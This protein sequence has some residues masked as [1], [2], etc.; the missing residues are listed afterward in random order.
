MFTFGLTPPAVFGAA[1]PKG[2]YA[3]LTTRGWEAS[4]TWNDKVGNGK[5]PFRYNVRLTLSD[6]K[7][8]IDRYNNP[9]KLISDFYEGQTLGE[10]WG[11]ETEGFF[12]DAADIASHAKQNPQMRAS[13]S[14]IWYPGDIKLRDLNKDNLINVGENKVGNSGDRRIIGN[15][16]PRYNFG[17]NLGADYNNFSFSTFFQG[18]GK[19]QWYPSTEA[20]MFWGQY[21]RPYNNIPIFH[22]G[23]MWTP[24]NINA[25]FPR[26]M[27]RA[28]SNSTTRTLGV[29]QTRY[30]QNVAYVRMKNIQVGYNL[31]ANLISRIGAHSVRVYFS[32]ENLFTY[33]PMYK[34]VKNTIDVENAVA[35]DQ[36]L[37]TG[38]AG[39]GY[40]YP[41]LKSFSFGINLG[42]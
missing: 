10:I 22:L 37:N 11:Y 29:A 35:A 3:D 36:D 42:F 5:K 38:N 23:K 32:G 20:E 4:L 6:N 40:N 13:P 30:L 1:T 39:D 24:D 7:S 2:N 34:I 27:S 12:I 17:V 21:N 19:Q 18:V 15:S 14:N 31:P 8:V 33:S 9:D 41:L 25:Y 26:T 16:A 28:A